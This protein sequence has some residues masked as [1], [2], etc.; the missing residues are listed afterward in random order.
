MNTGPKSTI[1]ASYVIV[2]A[3]Q[4]GRR[5]AETIKELKPD[6]DVLLIGD[7]EHL[8]Y[9]RPTLSK[10][11]LL[12]EEHEEGMFIRKREFYE[13]SGIRLLLGRA[14]QSID[15][16]AHR[17]DLTD[18]GSVI[19]GKLLLAT[20]S[21]A[22][23]LTCSVGEASKVHY[24]RS[25]SD[26]RLL[27]KEMIDGRRIAI[28][29]GGFIGLEVGAAARALGCDVTV[30]EPQERLLKRSLPAI[31]ASSV[32]RLHESMGV[33]FL[34]GRTPVSVKRNERNQEVVDLDVGVA[35][36]DVIIAGIGSQPNTELA[37]KAGLEVE[38]GIVVDTC[39][40]T[41]D[42]NIY[43]AGDVTAH[44]SGL[45]GRR[46]RIESWQVAEYQSVVAAKNMLG[47]NLEYEE[48]P[49][50]WSDQYQWN[51][52]ALGSFD[53]PGE[54][55]VRGDTNSSCFSVWNVGPG[56][57]VF[58]V[59]AVNNGRDVS[60]ARKLLKGGARLIPSKLQQ[61]AL[62]LRDCFDAR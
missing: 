61:P 42:P 49:W 60:V 37:E 56:G 38:N 4:A 57:Q 15:R 53:L 30:V 25:L 51:I 8:P 33:R 54:I 32:Q 23:R 55:Y 43:A 6:A 24:L 7:E 28:L 18:G 21:R 29:G 12:S 16:D 20:G 40:R 46:A 48:V 9:D 39:C 14:V 2:G 19:F 5:A 11:V 44:F 13:T 27:R 10:Q 17:I 1:A 62:A 35:T 26:A 22:R 52:Q 58:A 50:L 41:R 45:L 31:L 34:I 3:G 47:D 36:A 59:A